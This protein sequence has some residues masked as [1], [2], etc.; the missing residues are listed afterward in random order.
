MVTSGKMAA[1][2]SP[3]TSPRLPSPP[4][5]PEVQIGP[6]SPGVSA[7]QGIAQLDKEDSTTLDNGATRRIRPG[8]K[9]VDMASGPSLV[10]LAEVSMGMIWTLCHMP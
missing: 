1:A 4:P 8:T 5:F 3:S 10:P 9:A 2:M 6:R 7:A